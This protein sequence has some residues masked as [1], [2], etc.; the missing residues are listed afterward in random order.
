MD[1][2]KEPDIISE[3]IKVRLWWSEH[4]ERMPEE[5]IVKEVF[6][7][8][9]EGKG[10]NFCKS[11]HTNIFQSVCSLQFPLWVPQLR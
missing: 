9:P 1:L 8:L 5:R 11:F 10:K 7:N 3:I 6:K 4:V 2:H